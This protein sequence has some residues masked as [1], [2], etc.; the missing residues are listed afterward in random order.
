MKKRIVI[1]GLWVVAPNGIGKNEFWQ[2]LIS[3][4]QPPGIIPGTQWYTNS[5]KFG[6]ELHED[7]IDKLMIY[8]IRL[9]LPL[10]LWKPVPYRIG[11][12]TH[13]EA[14]ALAQGLAMELEKKGIK[15]VPCSGLIRIKR[16]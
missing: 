6:F 13:Y 11:G 8:R 16:N 4:I 7:Y 1:T 3:V 2:A 12:K 14:I 9:L 15:I 10:V 5:S